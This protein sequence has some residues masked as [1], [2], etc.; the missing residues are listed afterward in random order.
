[1]GRV[2]I[3]PWRYLRKRP[4]QVVKAAAPLKIRPELK[5]VMNIARR[6]EERSQEIEDEDYG[7]IESPGSSGPSVAFGATRPSE[8]AKAKEQGLPH[9]KLGHKQ[10]W[11]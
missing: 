6:I 3:A 11:L 1:M 4:V 8:L 2:A 5:K 7:M 10:V 9:F